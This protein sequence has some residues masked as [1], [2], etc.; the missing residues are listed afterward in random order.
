MNGDLIESLLTM[1]LDVYRQYEGQDADTGEIKKEW[2]YSR[3]VPCSAKGLI[4]NSASTR[5]GDRQIISNKYTN[6]QYIEVRTIDKLTVRDKITNITNQS[7]EIIWKELNFPTE[8][9]TV[10][11]VFGTT[12]ISDPF[13]NILAYNST[14]KRSENQ[15]IGQ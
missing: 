7:G 15:Q 3:T 9:P 8:T 14:L 1:T 5:T 10:F 4:S 13:G 6:E 2:S 12:P 11:E